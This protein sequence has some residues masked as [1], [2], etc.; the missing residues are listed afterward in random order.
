MKTQ[1]Q[2]PVEDIMIHT[3][4]QGP[5]LALVYPSVTSIKPEGRVSLKDASPSGKLENQVSLYKIL[6][7]D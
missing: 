1:D 4:A 7:K 5:R 3:D 2:A 6:C